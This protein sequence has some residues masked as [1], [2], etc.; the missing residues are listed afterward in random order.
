MKRKENP[1]DLTVQNKKHKIE[2]IISNEIIIEILN[3]L[4]INL[5]H[6]EYNDY[7]IVKKRDKEDVARPINVIKSMMLTS[8]N[9]KHLFEMCFKEFFVKNFKVTL[10]LNLTRGHLMKSVILNSIL[11][12]NLSRSQNYFLMLMDSYSPVTY[13]SESDYEKIYNI[14][15]H[16]GCYDTFYD[17]IKGFH[18]PIYNSVLNETFCSC[19]G[20]STVYCNR[21]LDDFN[22][23]RNFND[24]Y[25]DYD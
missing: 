22:R 13:S 14:F 19:T 25:F 1:T 10:N 6:V 16:L 8:R 3:C 2:K 12:V 18:I 9:F 5:F 11:Y 7:E 17:I 24:Y 4:M 20:R 15:R 21:T 23:F